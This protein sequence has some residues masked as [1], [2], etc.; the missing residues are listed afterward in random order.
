MIIL[1]CDNRPLLNGAKYTYLSDNIASGVTSL[2]VLNATDSDFAANAYLLLGQFGSEDAEIVQAFSVNSSTGVIVTTTA[3][4]FS[5]PESARVTVL[6]YN[7]VVFYHTSTSTFDIDSAL[8]LTVPAIA[9]QPS[10]W[11]TTYSD[12]VRSTG[13]G[14]Y[15]FHNQATDVYSQESN[16]IPYAG[17][18]SDTT[19]N[20]ISDFYSMLGNKEQKLVTRE[21]A[22][23][24]ASEGYGILKK[25]LNLTNTEYSGSAVSTFTIVS[26]TI[27]YDLPSDFDHLVSLVKG[28]NTSD[29]GISGGKTPIEYISLKDAYGYN[30]SEVRYY[31]RGTKIGFL[32]TPSANATYH[33]IYQKK[34]A[35]LNL[36]TDEVELP[37]GGEYVIKDW[38]L[39]RAYKKFQNAAE[40][41]SSFEAFTNG[42]NE[43]IVASVKRDANLDTWSIDPTCNV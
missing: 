22:L 24:W 10:D 41:K 28:A 36:N 38:M 37:S 3:T 29:P 17:F 14:W 16:G 19:E 31:I 13:Y 35:R 8:E 1:E 9:I 34:A 5:H 7:Q 18:E 43:M 6:P 4:K 11:F 30:G 2:T 33:Y 42:L 40:S 21:D 39:Y 23:S 20:I 25:K 27:E 12:E 15:T 26:G 32:P